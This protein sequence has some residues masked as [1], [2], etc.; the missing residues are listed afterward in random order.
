MRVAGIPPG[1]WYR[2]G[3]AGPRFGLRCRAAVPAPLVRFRSRSVTV[4]RAVVRCASSVRARSKRSINASAALATAASASRRMSGT[5]APASGATSVRYSSMSCWIAPARLRI[6]LTRRASTR[7]AS[8]REKRSRDVSGVSVSGSSWARSHSAQPSCA[9]RRASSAPFAFA[10]AS[11]RRACRRSVSVPASPAR[12]VSAIHAASDAAAASRSAST[13]SSCFR[14]GRPPSGWSSPS[15]A[16]AASSASRVFSSVSR[17]WPACASISRLTGGFALGSHRY[18]T[19][20]APRSTAP[21][22]IAACCPSTTMP[23]TSDAAPAS[24][25]SRGRAQRRSPGPPAPDC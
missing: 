1:R 20:T 17:A 22:T 13:P 7:A 19:P 23:T 12:V 21:R 4:V 8:T 5:Y 9:P 10:S 2:P 3:T 6:S 11:A 18:A 25:S 24:A 14:S 15:A 16:A